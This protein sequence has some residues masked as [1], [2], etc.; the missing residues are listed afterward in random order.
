MKR[1]LVIAALFAVMSSL[2]VSCALLPRRAE[3]AQIALRNSS[4]EQLAG[5]AVSE[6]AK[7]LGKGVRLGSISPAMKGETY[8]IARRPDPPALPGEAVVSWQNYRG[9]YRKVTVDLDEALRSATGNP[10][11]TLVFELKNGGRIDV[12]LETIQR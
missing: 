4:G 12:Y 2:L 1:P 10:G 11:E 3:P 5:L 9:A 6:K 8:L 7:K